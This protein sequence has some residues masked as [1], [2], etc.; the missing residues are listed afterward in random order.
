MLFALP[1][2]VTRGG[3]DALVSFC[4]AHSITLVTADMASLR[5]GAAFA[6]MHDESQVGMEAAYKAIAILRDGKKPHQIPIMQIERKEFIWLNEDTM[7][8]QGLTLSRATINLMRYSRTFTT[9]S[10]KE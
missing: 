7:H 5:A 9:K 2:D 3:I 4:N 1:S 6:F 8:Q 10:D